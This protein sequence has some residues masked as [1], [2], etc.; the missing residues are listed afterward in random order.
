MEIFMMKASAK[1]YRM[2][3]KEKLSGNWGSAIGAY[4]VFMLLLMVV[5]YTG[6][7]SLIL[8]GAMVVGFSALWIGLFR[9]GK[10]DFADLFSGFKKDFVNTLIFGLLYQIFITLWSML[11]IIP[12]IV[13]MYSYSMAPYILADNPELSGNDA[14]TASCKLMDGKKARLFCLDFSFIGWIILSVLTF[15]ILLLW[16]EPWMYAARADFYESI[17]D[18]VPALIGKTVEA[19]AA[20]EAAEETPAEENKDAE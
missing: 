17:K 19:P 13:K 15:G 20:E 1:D 11:F 6:I 12:G 3:A 14:I 5:A 8:Y 7:G 2:S 4:V 18:E 9:N 16:I 10:I